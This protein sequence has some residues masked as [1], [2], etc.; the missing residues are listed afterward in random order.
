LKQFPC[1]RTAGELGIIHHTLSL[2]I[3]F[4]VIRAY[5]ENIPA[6]RI[7]LLYDKSR[8]CSQVLEYGN[9]NLVSCQY[10]TLYMTVS[11]SE[12]L[13]LSSRFDKPSLLQQ[14]YSGQL[15]FSNPVYFMGDFVERKRLDIL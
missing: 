2:C 7:P 1:Y 13:Q 8:Y 9:N 14:S 11:R 12:I 15:L 10:S 3:R 4:A 5:R 6:S